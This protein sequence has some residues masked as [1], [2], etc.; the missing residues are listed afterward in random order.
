MCPSSDR[1]AFRPV[2]V[3]SIYALEQGQKGEGETCSQGVEA[4]I[5]SFATD[6]N[7]IGYKLYIE[8][9]GKILIS[10]QVKSDESIAFRFSTS[11]ETSCC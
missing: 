7:T 1:S 8:E 9:T 3:P 2:R 10:N 6:C 4:V 5:L 11:P